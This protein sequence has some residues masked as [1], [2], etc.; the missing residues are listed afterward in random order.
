MPWIILVTNQTAAKLLAFW[1]WQMLNPQTSPPVAQ[2]LQWH[3]AS[4]LLA[5]AGAAKQAACSSG[6]NCAVFCGEDFDQ[7]PY[8]TGWHWQF[9]QTNCTVHIC[10]TRAG[11][12]SLEASEWSSTNAVVPCDVRKNLSRNLLPISI[13]LCFT[14]LLGFVLFCYTVDLCRLEGDWNDTRQLIC[15]FFVNLCFRDPNE[16]AKIQGLNSCAPWRKV[17]SMIVTNLP[18]ECMTLNTVFEYLKQLSSSFGYWCRP[19]YSQ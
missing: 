8:W 1:S 5:N 12:S 2:S 18:S 9:D 10:E 19:S 11:A 17:G 16:P 4:L 14:S 6:M 3:H 13:L 7:H 15:T